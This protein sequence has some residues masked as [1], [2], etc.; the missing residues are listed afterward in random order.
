MFRPNEIDGDHSVGSA[1][2]SNT[3]QYAYAR[4]DQIG[5]A[6]IHSS[7]T[8]ELLSF[9]SR[10]VDLR[11]SVTKQKTR[12]GFAV[13]YVQVDQQQVGIGTKVPVMLAPVRANVSQFFR[14][15]LTDIIMC[16]L[17]S[18]APFQT[19]VKLP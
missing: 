12:L 19:P 6:L 2:N 4:L 7:R 10:G 5:L 1:S 14:F 8:M 18:Y 11:I 15:Y 3:E 17:V 16:V 13:G 9:S